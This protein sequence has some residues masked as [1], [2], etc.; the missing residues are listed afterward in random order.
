[1]VADLSARRAQL[2]DAIEAGHCDLAQMD[3]A[4]P[5]D[6]K[7]PFRRPSTLLVALMMV[8]NAGYGVPT[9]LESL[10]LEDWNRT[11]AVTLTSAFLGIK[12]TVPI[13]QRQGG[14]VI[15]NT[16]SISGISADYGMGG[17]SGPGHQ[18][19]SQRPGKRHAS[20]PRQSVFAPAVST[21]RIQILGV[22][23]KMVSQG[24]GR[25]PSHGPHG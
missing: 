16:A 15:V 14:G 3:A 9:R 8:N 18:S 20:H 24:D 23:M 19:H 25:R 10:S 13:F 4:E 17:Y 12:Y 21:P 6:F 7:A 5:D 2:V 22:T 1:M 11:L